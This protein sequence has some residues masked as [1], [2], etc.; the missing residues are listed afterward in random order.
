MATSIMT[1]GLRL[2]F[3]TDPIL[4]LRPPPH[5][6]ISERH[7][8]ALRPFIPSYLE[9]GIIREILTP[10]PLYFSSV[11]PVPKKN[12]TF[13]P[14]I[15]LSRLNTMLKVPKFKMETVAKIA[16]CLTVP[17]WG[18]TVDLEDAFFH[19]PIAW[20]YHK[21][22]AFEMDGHI[23]VFQ[24]LPFGL[25]PAP[26]AFSRIVKPI[27]SH[28][29]ELSIMLF[30]LLDDFLIL[31]P[32][33][34]QLEEDAQTVMSCFQTLGLTINYK[35]SKLQPS[36]VVEYLGVLFHLETLQLSIP[37]DKI[38]SITLRSKEVALSRFSTR[39]I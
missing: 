9:K 28:L 24:F 10:Q 30:S 29:H 20:E 19:V 31:A 37:Q 39:R 38:D 34:V 16:P 12:N 21:Y 27:K 3:H 35:K 23:Y 25:S 11:F 18:I 8:P 22:F 36:Q 17:L 13:R 1:V 4:S 26:W 7:L 15:N 33:Q 14:V 2:S 5:A 6:R 32:S